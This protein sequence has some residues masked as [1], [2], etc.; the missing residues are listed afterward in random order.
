MSGGSYDYVCFNIKEFANEIR[1]KDTN[2]LRAEF[3]ELVHDVATI[4]KEI[5]WADSC[6][7]SQE[8]ANRALGQFFMKWK[9]AQ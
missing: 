2:P 1:D 8:D 3:S 4:A 5:E 9:K 7:T 6:D